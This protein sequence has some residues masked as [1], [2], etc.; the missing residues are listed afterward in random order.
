LKNPATVAGCF[1]V[2]VPHSAL[3]APHL[4]LGVP[5]SAL[6]VPHSA[7]GVPHLKREAPPNFVGKC[8]SILRASRLR[9]D[10]VGKFWIVRGV[11]YFD[12][13]WS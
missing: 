3:G 10:E 11:R 1:F 13:R 2:G 5:H 7:L 4:D 12:A 9:R 6:G 8:S